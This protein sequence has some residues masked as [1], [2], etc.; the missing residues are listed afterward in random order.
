MFAG[1]S[2]LAIS[3]KSKNQDRAFDLLKLIYSDEFQQQLAKNGLGPANDKFTSLM[4]DD[5]FAKAAIAAASNSKLTPASPEWA[6]V[7]SASVMEEFF[8]KIARGD[9]SRRR[10]RPPTPS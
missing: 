9:E 7:E 4:G 3:A 2:N 1:G 8:G 5:E 6:A 10:R